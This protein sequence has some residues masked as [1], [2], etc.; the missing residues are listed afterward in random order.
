M[1][2]KRYATSDRLARLPPAMSARSCIREAI[3]QLLEY[4]FW[5][6]AQEAEKLIVVGEPSLDRDAEQYLATLRARFGLPLEYRQV[7]PLSGE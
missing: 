4:A 7:G 3:S 5:P 6:G 1:G 2:R